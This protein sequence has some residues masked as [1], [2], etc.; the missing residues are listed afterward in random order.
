LTPGLKAGL[1]ALA[2]AGRGVEAPPEVEARLLAAFRSRALLGIQSNPARAR[3]LRAW[4]WVPAVAAAAILA[5]AVGHPRPAVEHL[6]RLAEKQDQWEKEI[7]KNAHFVHRDETVFI[8]PDDPK[9]NSQGDA[10]KPRVNGTAAGSIARASGG[11]QPPLTRRIR[12]A[13]TAQTRPQPREIATEFFPLVEFGPPMEDGELV[14]VSLP[15]S[16]MRDVGLPVGEDRLTDRVQADV[17][18]SN[19]TA[20]AVRFVKNMQ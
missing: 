18:V 10:A 12:P 9:T 4:R 19:G 3:R 1:R 13:R 20:M 17:L 15:A 16:A 14:R 11:G 7:R 5:I 6:R 2:D 8:L